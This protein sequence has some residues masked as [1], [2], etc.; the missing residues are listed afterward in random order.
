MQTE[1]SFWCF[2]SEMKSLNTFS[3]FS[4]V[5]LSTTL[6]L[7][8]TVVCCVCPQC[9]APESSV[10]KREFYLNDKQT[11]IDTRISTSPGGDWGDLLRADVLPVQ[12]KRDDVTASLLD[13]LHRS[14][15]DNQTSSI[16]N[17][18]TSSSSTTVT[19]STWVP[20]LALTLYQAAK[21]CSFANWSISASF[22]YI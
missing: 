5:C 22:T 3:V 14:T 18:N 20:S 19:T 16:N 13:L 21:P 2:L 1:L 6:L 7:L 4:D 12:H 15:K 17:R 9:Q 10:L 11:N 8:A